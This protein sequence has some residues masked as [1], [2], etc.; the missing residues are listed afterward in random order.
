MRYLEKLLDVIAKFLKNKA[1][2]ERKNEIYTSIEEL[3]TSKIYVENVRSILGSSHT[4]AKTACEKAVH[5]GVLDKYVEVL[6]PDGSQAGAYAASE[7]IPESV[8]CWKE[9]GWD[10]YEME[11]ETSDLRKITF[12]KLNDIK[13][14]G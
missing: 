7:G 14:Y 11:V 1:S 3:E 6:C 2:E 9:D 10:E 5:Q 12:Y 4:V 13:S 8:I